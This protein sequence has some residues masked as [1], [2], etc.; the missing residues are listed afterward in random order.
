MGFFPDGSRVAIVLPRAH[1]VRVRIRVRARVLLSSSSFSLNLRLTRSCA[2]ALISDALICITMR[3]LQTRVVLSGRSREKLI[4]R[5]LLLG[6][7]RGLFGF[8]ILE[9][10]L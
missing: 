6:G 7:G 1:R 9:A 4:G 8:K 10:W 2:R 5:G 3:P